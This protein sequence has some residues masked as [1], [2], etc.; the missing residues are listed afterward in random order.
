MAAMDVSQAIEFL[1]G[2]LYL[3]ITALLWILV[4]IFGLMQWKT[5]RPWLRRGALVGVLVLALHLPGLIAMPFLLDARAFI[6]SD[7]DASL[8]PFLEAM[9]WLGVAT[10]YVIALVAV[11]HLAL[12]V[13][14]GQ[15]LARPGAAYPDLL[16]RQR[17]LRG[18]GAAA[19]VGI[20]GTLLTALF[21]WAFG[22]QEGHLIQDLVKMM[23]ALEDLSAPVL[24]GVFGPTIL[25]AAVA[26]EILFRGILQRGMVRLLGGGRGAVIASIV[27][28]SAF[29][30]LG[31]QGMTDPFWAKYIQIFLIGLAFG[32]LSHRRSVEAAIVAHVALNASAIA[33]HL[34]PLLVPSLQ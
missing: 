21:F 32:T 14:L 9:I 29:W 5:I 18:W 15:W 30:A 20:L 8:L 26:E 12:Q 34:L 7:V 25:A 3:A 33:F 17:D 24:L 13:G 23:P 1:L 28:V 4:L 27:T 19:G 6:P 16:G 10:Q 31:H 2:L 11:F 22:I